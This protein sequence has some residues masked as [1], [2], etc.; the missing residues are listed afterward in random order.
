[1]RVFY[2][3]IMPTITQWIPGVSSNTQPFPG[4]SI[5]SATRIDRPSAEMGIK[6]KMRKMKRDIQSARVH[7]GCRAAA[8]IYAT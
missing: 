3:T 7:Y 1:M 6:K 5:G 4:N 8:T 2:Q